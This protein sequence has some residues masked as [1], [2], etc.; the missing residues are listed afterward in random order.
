MGQ[1]ANQAIEDAIVL[2]DCLD[3]HDTYTTAYEEYYNKRFPRTKRIV[4][5]AGMMYKM[6]HSE[7][8]F[9]KQAMEVLLGSMVKGGL[10]LNQLEKEIIEECPVSVDKILNNQPAA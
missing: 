1:G 10:I 5:F 7:N 4:Q 2:A 8:W 9:M 6:Y 3:R